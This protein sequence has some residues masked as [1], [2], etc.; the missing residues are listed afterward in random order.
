MSEEKTTLSHNQ[1]SAAIW[2]SLSNSKSVNAGMLLLGF[3]D[4]F[5]L[6]HFAD[7]ILC[8][9]SAALSAP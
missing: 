1:I 2:S 9:P 6:R 8:I 5:G 3:T 7:L 4:L